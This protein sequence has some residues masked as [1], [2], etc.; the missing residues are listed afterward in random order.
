MD[1]YNFFNRILDENLSKIDEIKIDEIKDEIIL[2]A[3]VFGCVNRVATMDSKQAFD[4]L[5]NPK[6]Y[7]ILA[8]L[9]I[10]HGPRTWA[11][12]KLEDTKLLRKI[13]KENQWQNIT[14]EAQKRLNQ[15]SNSVKFIKE[16]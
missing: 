10:N 8:N 7:Y 1:Y 13:I 5:K 15:I 12:R 14:E 3:L 11:I 2:V 9:D 16:S 4:L 6:S